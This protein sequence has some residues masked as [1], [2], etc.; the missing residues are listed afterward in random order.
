MKLWEMI[1]SFPLVIK[2][3]LIVILCGLPPATYYPFMFARIKFWKSDIGKSMLTKGLA[4]ASVFW[5]G[6]M[7]LPGEVYGWTWYPWL[8]FATNCL[9]VV[10]VWYQVVVMRRVQKSGQLHHRMGMEGQDAD[11]EESVA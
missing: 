3:S 6:I 10:A 5:V 11:E 9:L 2:L 1:V 8:Q 7:S 4:L